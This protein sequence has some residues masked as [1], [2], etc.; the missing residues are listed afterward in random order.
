MGA[1]AA[2]IILAVV[3][4]FLLLNL[5]PIWQ[6]HFRRQ[7]SDRFILWLIAVAV[8]LNLFSSAL[9][10]FIS[11]CPVIRDFAISAKHLMIDIF[12]K[13]LPIAD[14]DSV[15][16]C[17]MATALFIIGG[18]GI[19]RRADT[20]SHEQFKQARRK[21]AAKEL[22]EHDALESL[23]T[24]SI[25]E[26]KPLMINLKNRKVY[27]GWVI[28]DNDV[29]S[30]SERKYI[31]ILLAASGYRDTE[32]LRFHLESSDYARIISELIESGKKQS[33]DGNIIALRQGHII[34]IDEI[35][36]ATPWLPEIHQAVETA[37]SDKKHVRKNKS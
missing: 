16:L 17:S 32:T 18:F 19:W 9:I 4:A 10:Y 14:M 25:D 21:K 3:A 11:L 13:A 20:E 22:G 23:I 5:T 31:S 8:C 15:S 30:P 24:Y 34:R 33:D 35:V 27:I 2:P 29:F 26:F 7:T 12:G 36:S 6:F 1:V 37:Y 28:K